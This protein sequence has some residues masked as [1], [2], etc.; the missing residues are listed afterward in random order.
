M[1]VLCFRRATAHIEM[2]MEELVRIT[3]PDGIL[4]VWMAS[5]P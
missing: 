5:T 2:A 4:R 3:D 1:S